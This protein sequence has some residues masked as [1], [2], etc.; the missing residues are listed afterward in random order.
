M[1]ETYTELF[2]VPFNGTVSQL[3]SQMS[4]IEGIESASIGTRYEEVD[5][6][7]DCE[8]QYDSH[9]TDRT[10]IAEQIE[11]ISGVEDVVFA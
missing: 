5:T 4:V 1:S 6:E 10:L 9:A 8:I 7:L 2:C 11:A 3:R